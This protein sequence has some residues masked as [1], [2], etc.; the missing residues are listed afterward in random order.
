MLKIHL[1]L[2]HNVNI[3]HAYK[4]QTQLKWSWIDG[5]NDIMKWFV[6]SLKITICLLKSKHELKNNEKEVH[7]I[8]R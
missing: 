5:S 1:R 4:H 8:D 3:I 2:A 7:I 6:Q